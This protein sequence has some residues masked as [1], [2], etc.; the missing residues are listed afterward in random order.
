MHQAKRKG[1]TIARRAFL[2]EGTTPALVPQVRPPVVVGGAG[3][4]G[5]DQHRGNHR[6]K[7]PEIACRGVGVPEAGLGSQIEEAGEQLREI[8]ADPI[9]GKEAPLTEGPHLVS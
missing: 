5:R 4:D 7:D 9:P 8:H 1:P 2:L 6:E 3:R